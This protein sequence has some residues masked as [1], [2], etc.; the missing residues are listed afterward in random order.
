MEGYIS[1]SSYRHSYHLP[2]FQSADVNS[3][4]AQSE[5]DKISI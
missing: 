4:N 1:A 5:I 3:S 2:S